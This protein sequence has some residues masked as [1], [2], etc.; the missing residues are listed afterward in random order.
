M[1]KVENISK[2][3]GKFEV[4]KRLSF[5]IKTGNCLALL[6]QN[7]A[8][9]S[10]TMKILATL[11]YPDSG[12]I[13]VNDINLLENP[14]AVREIL[15]YSPEHLPI[16][17]NLTVLEYLDFVAG[18]RK[19]ARREK[20]EAIDFVLEKCWLKEEGRK[21]CS[22]LSKG[23]RQRLS[24][25]QAIIHKPSFILLDEPSSGLDPKQI[26]ETRELIYSLKQDASVLISTHI[27][28]EARRIADDVAIIHLGEIA[29]IKKPK[30]FSDFGIEDEFLNIVGQ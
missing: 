16:Y 22:L 26:I 28:E 30:E 13:S 20:Q 2:K 12:Q 19:I 25:A 24:I 5:E 17:P 4:L 8:G 1:L 14:N 3:F 7:G 27:V 18:I 9:K 29:S 10:T 11:L 6:G 15:G 21:L 23:Y